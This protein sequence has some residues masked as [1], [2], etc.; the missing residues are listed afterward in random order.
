VLVRVELRAQR[1]RDGDLLPA[2]GVFAGPAG[3][4]GLHALLDDVGE[5]REVPVRGPFRGRDAR[6]GGV[7]RGHVGGTLHASGDDAGERRLRALPGELRLQQPGYACSGRIPRLVG[8]E[9]KLLIRPFYSAYLTYYHP[10]M[11]F[12]NR[13]F[14]LEDLFSS[15]L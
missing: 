14:I 9:H 7:R 15:V 4:R 1:G 6:R 8:P 3:P 13:I 2:R 11:P 12:G 10:A 5:H